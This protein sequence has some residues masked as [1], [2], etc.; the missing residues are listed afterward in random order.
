MIGTL[1]H[2][3]NGEGA[4]CVYVFIEKAL[5]GRIPQNLSRQRSILYLDFS[6][7]LAALA[8]ALAS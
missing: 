7:F 8:L 4:D 1:S 6:A 2:R 3:K 5:P